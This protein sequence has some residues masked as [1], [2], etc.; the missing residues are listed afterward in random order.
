MTCSRRRVDTTAPLGLATLLLPAVLLAGCGSTD[1]GEPSGAGDPGGPTSS[2]ATGPTRN[3]VLGIDSTW[4]WQLQGPLDTS[5][6]VDVY[7]IDLFTTTAAEIAALRAQGRTVVCYFSAGSWEPWRPDAGAFPADDL[8]RPLEGFEEERWVDVRSPAVRE[9]TA[10]RLDL[11][12]AKGCDGVEPDNVTGHLNDTG[13]DL[14]AEDQLAFNRWLAEQA[15]AR[16][17]LVGLK[18]DLEQIPELLAWFDFAVNEQC[19]EFDE[20]DAY[21]PFLAAGKPVFNVEY[22]E[23]FLDDP[24]P[25]CER[26]RRQGLRTLVLPPELDGSFVVSCDP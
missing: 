7:D 11:A 10:A 2:A 21:D 4:R 25:L 5:H 22:A 9:I 24:G 20:C 1:G 14:T 8:G 6:D 12:A 13:F 17:L 23:E 18:N 16:G 15:R 26:A 3:A 19:H